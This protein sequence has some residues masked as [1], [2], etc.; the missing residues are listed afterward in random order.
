MVRTAAVSGLPS[1]P[2]SMLALSIAMTD[3]N[4]HFQTTRWSLVRAAGAGVST[5]AG[6][7]ALG[8][9]CEAYWYPLYAFARRRGMQTS[10]AQESVQGFFA[11]ILDGHLFDVADADKGRFHSFLLKAFCNYLSD[12]HRCAR[13][14]KRGGGVLTVSLDW[15][16][17]EQ[18]Y[19]RE[20]ASPETPEAVFDRK[21][22]LAVLNRAID[23][24]RADFD[25]EGRRELFELLLP[26]M[27]AEAKNRTYA[28]IAEAVGQSETM[29]KVTAH[30]L[31]RRFRKA[32][33][34]AVADT[35]A[36]GDVDD[37]LKR[38]TELVGK[39]S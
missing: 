31:K 12:Q 5:N 3:L 8:Q 20:P 27:T 39:R 24:L 16:D 30:R 36:D 1:S 34:A 15:S 32:L 26:Y 17:G 2:S 38:L 4:S 10:D 9:L 21:W 6:Q 23:E 35:V 29:V 25:R 14:A 22:A 13:A 37:E 18:R 33:R 7:A 19:Q 28:E 11:A